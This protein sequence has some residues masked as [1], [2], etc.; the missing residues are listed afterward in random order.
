[1]VFHGIL[2]RVCSP[3]PLVDLLNLIFDDPDVHAG[4]IGYL[5]G[6]FLDPGLDGIQSCHPL[7]VDAMDLL[8][9]IVT[10]IVQVTTIVDVNAKNVFD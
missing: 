3:K 10:H 4:F 7:S 6:I 5:W 8:V 2:Q 1:M 9:K